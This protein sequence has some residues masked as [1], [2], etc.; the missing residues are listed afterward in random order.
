MGAAMAD[1]GMRFVVVLVL[2]IRLRLRTGRVLKMQ[3][4][5]GPRIGGGHHTHRIGDAL[6]RVHKK[7]C[8]QNRM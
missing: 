1:M 2:M 7:G 8:S 6:Q 4:M 5:G 3:F